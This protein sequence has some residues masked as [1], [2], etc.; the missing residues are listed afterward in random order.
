LWQA[1]GNRWAYSRYDVR[2][3]HC[4]VVDYIHRRATCIKQVSSAPADPAIANEQAHHNE[5]IPSV[6]KTALSTEFFQMNAPS[7]SDQ[8]PVTLTVS[9]RVKRGREAE[10]ETW[11]KGINQ[12]A[13]SFPGFCGVNVIRPSSNGQGEYV[14]IFR[15]DS[16]TNLKAWEESE[17]RR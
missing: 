16:Y 5:Q 11:L 13:A 15:F 2:N 10:Y 12:V 1:G 17:I 3:H 14:S 8:D 6:L 4:H 9:R 7:P